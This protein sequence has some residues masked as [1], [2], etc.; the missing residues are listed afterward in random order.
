MSSDNNKKLD[1]REFLK[2]S[3]VT[4]AAFAAGA[5]I[6]PAYA[7]KKQTT[8]AKKVI[9]IGIDGMDPRM[10]E[11]MMNAGRLPNFER[12]RRQGGYSLLGTS[13][14]PH[15]PVAWANFITG[16][17]PGVHG[18]FGFIHRDPQQ[19]HKIFN[20]ISHTVLGKGVFIGKYA[21]PL[22]KRPKTV[23]GRQGIPFWDYLDEAAIPSRVYLVPSN[24]PPS[25]SK[26]GY[27]KSLAGLGTPDLMGSMSTY[28]YFT[29]NGYTNQK[30]KDGEKRSSLVFE[31]ETAAAKLLGP[32]NS[33]L[34]KPQLTAVD[35]LVHRD[36]DSRTAVIEIQR[37]KILLKD[38]QWS[39]WVELDFEMAT[40]G[41]NKHISG[42]CRFY[43][44]QVSPNFSLYVSPL[45]I[46]PA[47]PAVRISEPDDFAVEISRDVGLFHTVGF[48]EEFKA[49]KN[50]VF[51]DEEYA[52]QCEMVLQGRLK[53]LDYA[54]EEYTDGLFFFYF[55][56]TDMQSHMFWWDTDEKN[57]V[58]SP[59]QAVEYHNH[60]K[61]LYGRM[62]EVVGTI[63]KRYGD[64]A[65]II[66]LSDHGFSY[67]TRYFN[68]NTWLRQNGYIRPSYCTTLFPQ[69]SG[70]FT[71]G[72]QQIGVDWSATRVYGLDINGLYL[73]LKGREQCGIVEPQEREALLEELITRLE[74]VRDVN[75]K[76][77]IR[78]VYR[79]DKIYSGPAMKYAPDLILGFYRGYRGGGTSNPGTI[80]EK[81]VADNTDAWGADHRFD[82]RE[83][84]GVLFCNR[85]FVARAPTLID[86]AP[87]ILQEFGLKSPPS[88]EGKS[89]FR[90]QVKGFY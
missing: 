27:H 22:F 78:K 53:L 72:N 24:Y 66:V 36:K 89:I 35:F 90:T 39:D 37:H 87:S 70:G 38:R 61:Q 15:S 5:G 64:K 57:P 16:A 12:L 60:I 29:E 68:L 30:D 34:R 51:T 69:K 67:F 26:Y 44:Q 63:L 48:S 25:R 81:V 50:S 88:M 56:S 65:T 1:R 4:A 11:Q 82:P 23:L 18:I 79:S 62:D 19:P 33:L 21:L 6:K 85:P 55:S 17:N 2:R 71:A 10:A 47:N 74:E 49:L 45:N 41:P 3:A 42:I 40:L 86:V 31:N 46:N 28:Q 9:V 13:N 8:A 75:G 80:A 43:L 84:P 32:P 54:L 83:V 7:T 59:Q 77:V 20:S 76:A 73:N 14:P 52:A 58:R